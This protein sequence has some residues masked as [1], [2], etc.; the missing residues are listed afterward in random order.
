[1]PRHFFSFPEEV[2]E[3]V[4][5]YTSTR[6]IKLN[7]RRY[8]QEPQYYSALIHSLEGT[9]YEGTYGIVRFEATA[10]DDR[11]PGSAESFSGADFAITATVSDKATNVRKAILF[12]AKLGL[13]AEMFPSA[14]AD[15]KDDIKKMKRFTRSPKVMEIPEE[16][17]TRQPQILSGNYIL[18]DRKYNS[19]NLSDYMVRRVL[20]TFDGDT[21]TWFVDEVQNSSLPTLRV[22]AG[23]ASR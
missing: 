3:A 17:G 19:L 14:L 12:Q 21:R 6:V 2:R 16:D 1:M 20:T 15:L 18:A 10:I 4:K 8:N 9:A 23:L 7:P 22:I 11:G 13:V 5:A